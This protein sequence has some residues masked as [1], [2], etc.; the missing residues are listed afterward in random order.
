MDDTSVSAYNPEEDI[1]PLMLKRGGMKLKQA[2]LFLANKV[3]E[4]SVF[5]MS[6]KLDH[7]ILLEK[8]M[9]ASYN[10]CKSYRPIT[11]ESIIGKLVQRMMRIRL[12][13][14]LESSNLLSI[15]QEAYR[16]DRNCNDLM[17]RLVQSI[18]EGWNRGETT[19]LCIFDFSSYF[20][21]VWRERLICKL[22]EAGVKGRMLRLFHDYISN[23]K[24][25]LVVNKFTTEW[26]ESSIGTP[27]GGIL[28]TIA[29]N[30]Y[31]SDSDASDIFSHGEFSDDNLKWVSNASELEA[32]QQLQCRVDAFISWCGEH[33]I[34]HSLDKIKLMVFRPPTSPR[35]YRQLSL[36]IGMDL[37]NEVDMYKILG[38]L[39]KND[40]DFDMHFEEAIK[41]H[42]LLFML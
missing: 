34:S 19:V 5:P 39:V 37:V 38:T 31:S 2:L 8:A 30:V 42:M 9:R 26:T 15:T 11:L 40:L 35:P 23:R 20:E 28:S 29:T 1:H 6:C 41:K 18:Q 7:K 10:M 17:L 4:S 33:N 3:L 36:R 12:E 13:W 14:H 21:S 24:F 32:L 22:Y 16:K 27:Q 25:R